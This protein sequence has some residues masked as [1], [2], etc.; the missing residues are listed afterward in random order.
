MYSIDLM[1]RESAGTF[2]L[3][4]QTKLLC[5]WI[6]R[7]AVGQDGRS[8]ARGRD[9]WV[10]IVCKDARKCVEKRMCVDIVKDH[11]RCVTYSI[12]V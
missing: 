3:R 5:A 8:R 1:S 2:T 10:K 4:A 9:Y 11:G 6:S 12:G 7:Q